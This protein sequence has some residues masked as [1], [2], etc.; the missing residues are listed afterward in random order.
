MKR[1]AQDACVQL[2]IAALFPLASLPASK[3]STQAPNTN[4]GSLAR[5]IPSGS[6]MLPGCLRFDEALS[7]DPFEPKSSSLMSSREESA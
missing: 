3:G 1:I 7:R 5:S 2:G 4:A 6:R